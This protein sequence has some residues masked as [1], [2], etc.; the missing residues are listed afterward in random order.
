MS[1]PTPPDEAPIAELLAAAEIAAASGDPTAG[2]ALVERALD[3]VDGPVP[4]AELGERRAELADAAGSADASRCWVA[5]ADAFEGAGRG[6]D[7]ARCCYFA[8]LADGAE[9]SARW[10]DRARSIGGDT[11]GWAHRAHALA[12]IDADQLTEAAQVN[13]RALH[14]ARLAGDRRLEALAL[15]GDAVVESLTGDLERAI[16]LQR[17]AVTVAIVAGDHH[18]V[19]RGSFNLVMMLL[20]ELRGSDARVALD[21]LVARRRIARRAGPILEAEAVAIELATNCGDLLLAEHD[22][23]HVLDRLADTGLDPHRSAY[24]RATCLRAL[25]EAVGTTPR[26]EALLGTLRRDAAA[27]RGGWLATRVLALDAVR[28]EDEG[29]ADAAI[30][31]L[32][33]AADDA[34]P[35]L[36][37]ELAVPLARLALETNDTGLLDRI[38]A[39]VAESVELRGSLPRLTVRQLAAV[40]A[41]IGPDGSLDQVRE[42]AEEWVRR[43]RPLEAGRLL[44]AAAGAATGTHRRTLAGDA[45]RLLAAAGAGPAARRAGELHEATVEGFVRRV[46]PADAPIFA[47]VDR[48]V[49]AA[50]L[51]HGV[52]L[53]RPAGSVLLEPGQPSAALWI[54]CS[55]IARLSLVTDGERSMTVELVD[56]GGTIGEP[57]LTGDATTDL[58][59]EAEDDLRYVAIPLHAVAWAHAR[60][61]RF[62][63]NLTA[64]VGARLERS[65]RLTSRIAFWT[66][67]RRLAQA[68]LE[69]DEQYGRGTL[70]GHRLMERPFTHF[71]L[72]ELVNARRETVGELLKGLRAEGVVEVRR[73]RLAILDRSALESRAAATA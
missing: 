62:A 15:L 59:V 47:G 69:L 65:R 40:R 46:E 45:R 17:E 9:D 20:D 24:V 51:R 25:V 67:E 37:C 23:R 28:A 19:D 64:L 27:D 49:V 53:H 56:P 22:A 26:T 11:S 5:A 33:E 43:E 42:V 61:Q 14:L 32:L 2:R 68:L 36:L 44:L 3:P 7:A 4:R 50:V 73:R 8:Y 18:A 21:D 31:G 13:A 39:L 66:V 58:Q 12:L 29:D 57:G 55:G 10:L 16:E 71:Q 34:N 72:A 60:S 35:L 70:D 38:D 63:A 41:A 30:A 1:A 52:E 54:V 6:D 48:S